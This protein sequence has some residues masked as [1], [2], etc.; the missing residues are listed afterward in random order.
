MSSNVN[1][2]SCLK[3]FDLD[4]GHNPDPVLPA[5]ITTF[6]DITNYPSN[7]LCMYCRMVKETAIKKPIIVPNIN[8]KDLFGEDLT[9]GT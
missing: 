2:E 4:R 9:S 5:R 6:K 7:F 1:N 3:N 8:I